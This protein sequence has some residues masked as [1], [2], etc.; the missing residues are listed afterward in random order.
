MSYIR[1]PI[2]NAYKMAFKILP[3]RGVSVFID[4]QAGRRMLDK[5]MEQASFEVSNF[6]NFALNPIS[7]QMESPGKRR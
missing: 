5:Y 2:L 4:G 3:N 6:G 7:N 1:N